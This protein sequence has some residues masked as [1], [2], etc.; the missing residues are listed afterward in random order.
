MHDS[1]ILG[2]SI[3]ADRVSGLSIEDRLRLMEQELASYKAAV[4]KLT[5]QTHRQT[6]LIDTSSQ[7]LSRQTIPCP[8]HHLSGE[9]GSE[10][11]DRDSKRESTAHKYHRISQSDLPPTRTF[12]ALYNMLS[13]ERSARRALEEQ[14]RGLQQDLSE[15][16]FQLSQPI[17]T[18]A[19]PV[20]MPQVQR[21]QY[22]VQSQAQNQGQ[23]YSQVQAHAQRQSQGQGYSQHARNLSNTSAA[24]DFHRIE[25]HRLTSR[26]SRSESLDSEEAA[27][28][29]EEGGL[30]HNHN[31]G[32][33]ERKQGMV[34]EGAGGEDSEET[35]HEMYLTPP[36]GATPAMWGR[37]SFEDDGM[38]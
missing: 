8:L 15:V 17:I 26:F 36:A 33:A 3:P 24:N 29:R 34:E 6:I 11:Q 35:P 12:T 31:R 1:P 30:A 4:H 10:E 19:S 20:Y 18:R 27:A 13:S 2:N 23:G 37:A 14:V 16:K 32:V 5:A 38:F 28:L 7:R 21:Q 25:N 9:Y 22:R